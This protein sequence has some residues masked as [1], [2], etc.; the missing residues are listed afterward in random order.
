MFEQ[1][2]IIKST[3]QAGAWI[4][5]VVTAAGGPTEPHD[6]ERADCTEIVAHFANAGV[7]ITEQ[8]ANTFWDRYSSSMQAGWLVLSQDCVAALDALAE[9]IEAGTCAVQ[10]L[11]ALRGT[12]HA[13]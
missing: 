10:C 11:R 7:V 1:N 8:E 2:V 3:A 13:V 6:A 9:D 12:I 5:A 4:K